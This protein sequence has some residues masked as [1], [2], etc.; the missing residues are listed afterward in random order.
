[1][2][3][4]SPSGA[5]RA[6]TG[7]SDTS[8]PRLSVLLS[9][10]RL[11]ATTNPYNK[12]L[13]TCLTP[14]VDTELFSWRRALGGS[15]DVL[16]VHWPE[17]LLRGRNRF[18]ALARLLLFLALMIST[19]LRRQAIVRTLHNV[20]PHE[21]PSAGERLA[22]TVLARRTAVAI[23]LNPHTP[24]PPATPTR[25]VLHGHYRDWVPGLAS[26][27]PQPVPGRILFFGIIRSFK[28]LD[29]LVDAFRGLTDPTVTLHIAG[30]V[31][32]HDSATLVTAAVAADR[33]ITART[34]FVPDSEL[35]AEIAASQLVVLPYR[36][37]HN[38]GA[39]LLALS[40]GR[41][42]L[43][44]DNE[45]TRSLADEVGAD[46]V[47]RFEAPVD[48]AALERALTTTAAST[49][50]SPDLSGREWADAALEHAAAYRD[51]A[52]SVRAGSARLRRRAG[53]PAPRAQ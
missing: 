20:E 49:G 34:E 21:R 1:M 17:R 23:R 40:I 2:S 48:S 7:V 41:A 26:E 12:Q 25:T 52:D 28:G 13:V 33:R 50:G 32:D 46:W 4:G 45:V 27:R 53:S 19:G 5:G 29:A 51:A 11:E 18:T 42:V 38:S 24:M 14:Y 36:A 30:R 47:L 35:V 43:V 9:F 22:T 8:G 37:M 15:Y 44:P 3:S 10:P 39:A 16:H 6:P 31:V